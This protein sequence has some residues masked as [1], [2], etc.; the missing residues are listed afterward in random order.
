M[1]RPPPDRVP[2][3]GITLDLLRRLDD[4]VGRAVTVAEPGEVLT[5]PDGLPIGVGPNRQTVATMGRATFLLAELRALGGDPS[6]YPNLHFID[7]E[8][9]DR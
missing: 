8:E 6:D 3:P 2:P 5:D 7:A 1:N 4:M 9:S